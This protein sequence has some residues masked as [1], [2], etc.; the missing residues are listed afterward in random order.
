M[1]EAQSQ[2]EELGEEE[3][4]GRELSER[5][6]GTRRE[7]DRVIIRVVLSFV[8]LLLLLALVCSLGLVGG[9]V[10]VWIGR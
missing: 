2:S 8:L 1:V 7:E 5:Q 6:P 4:L 9:C 10:G 3:R